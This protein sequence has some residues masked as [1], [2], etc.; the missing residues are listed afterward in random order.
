MY[1][2]FDARYETIPFEFKRLPSKEFNIEVEWDVEE[3]LGYFNTWSSVQNFIKV[4]EYNPVDEIDGKI[5]SAWNDEKKKS[6]SF[7]IFL[8]LGK[9]EK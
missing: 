7:P 5:K 6:F 2:F 1:K 3:L 9:I 8:L 4:N